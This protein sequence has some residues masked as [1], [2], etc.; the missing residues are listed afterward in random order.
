MVASAL[1]VIDFRELPQDGIRFEQFV[2]ELLVRSDFATQWT[3]VGPDGGR[4]LIVVERA[5][6]RLAPFERTWLVSCKHKAH[7]DKSV[8]LGDVEGVSDACRAIGAAGFLLVCSTQPSSG[9]VQRL[10]ELQAQ[11]GLLTKCWDGIELEKRLGTPATFP[12][13]HLFFPRSSAGRNWQVYASETQPAFW[14]ANYK[15]Y[16]IY[17]SSRI[18]H[19]FPNLK[20]VEEIVRRLESVHV[21]KPGEFRNHYLRPRA[22]YFDNKHENFHVFADY[23][24]PQ[25][26]G[27]EPITSPEVLD[28]IL[29]DGWG[30]YTDGVSSWYTTYWDIRYVEINP[31]SDRLH[32]DG[33]E[34]Y[35]PFM[36][37]YRLGMHR[38]PQS[39]SE[40]AEYSKLARRIEQEPRS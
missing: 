7:S 2:R 1:Q 35:E 21:P 9:V 6:G 37:N 11:T 40:A 36:E 3:G 33:K 16:F 4:D 23:L 31:Y 20:D 8:G 26:K 38:E 24:Y 13:L 5:E 15:D 27:Q 14:A 34:Y 30:L 22:V 32:F 29:K 17:L 10:R 25:G 18:A 12:L 19:T 28:D 39:L